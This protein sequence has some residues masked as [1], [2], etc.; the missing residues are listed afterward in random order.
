MN[1]NSL[2]SSFSEIAVYF[3]FLALIGVW[4]E[5]ASYRAEH[6]LAEWQKRPHFIKWV[7]KFM[8]YEAIALVLAFIIS[9][10]A[11]QL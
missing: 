4:V 7:F 10:V 9:S 2:S 3:T 1:L 5:F 8:K 6:R 11:Y